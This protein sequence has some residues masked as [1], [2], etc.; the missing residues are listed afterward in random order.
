MAIVKKLSER[1]EQLLPRHAEAPYSFGVSYTRAQ[2]LCQNY[3]T[4]FQKALLHIYKRTPHLGTEGD[5]YTE[6]QKQARMRPY[7]E[8]QAFQLFTERKAKHMPTAL[9]KMQKQDEP[10]LVPGGYIIFLMLD[11]LPG[12]RLSEELFWSL[13][14][15]EREAIREAFKT[16]YQYVSFSFCQF[17]GHRPRG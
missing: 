17:I 6:R 1:P 12:M 15:E 4:P 5:P 9:Y 14:G 10:D 2:F 7:E 13:D 8:I 11:M 16:A 3:S